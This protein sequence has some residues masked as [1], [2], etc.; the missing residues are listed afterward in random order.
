LEF[1][2]KDWEWT[3]DFSKDE[4][5]AVQRLTSLGVAFRPAPKFSGI[6]LYTHSAD[7]DMSRTMD[8][9]VRH[10]LLDHSRWRG[11]CFEYP[12]W[13]TFK[14]LA[15]HIFPKM[16]NITKL[17]LH[18]RQELRDSPFPPQLAH[19]LLSLQ[20]RPVHLH[21]RQFPLWIDDE[22]VIFSRLKHL[23]IDLTNYDFP[24]ISGISDI[25]ESN[26]CLT[27]WSW[28]TSRKERAED[29]IFNIIPLESLIL[30]SVPPCDYP[31]F[32]LHAP[33]LHS[34]AID[35]QVTGAMAVPLAEFAPHLENLHCQ[36]VDPNPFLKHLGP[37]AHLRSLTIM[38]ADSEELLD[39]PTKPQADNL[40]ND[41]FEM[42]FLRR[43]VMTLE[44]A[45]RSRCL[46][47]VT[48]Y[49][50]AIN[51]N[52]VLS[53][54]STARPE[55]RLLKLVDCAGAEAVSE[56]LEPEGGI[57]NGVRI[58]V[59]FTGRHG[60]AGDDEEDREYTPSSDEERL[61]GGD[62]QMETSDDSEYSCVTTDESLDILSDE[63]R[64]PSPVDS[65]LLIDLANADW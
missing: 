28:W 46:E 1:L 57:I 16:T 59:E 2:K 21:L 11:A 23:I 14:S 3:P 40:A 48:L 9:C 25:I 5:S 58:V 55:L 60:L 32:F 36:R 27:S 52:L 39:P 38:P 12:C 62:D 50:Q 19:A 31:L 24:S 64:T 42:T 65:L 18:H 7:T 6:S 13:R 41:D 47:E 63:G 54:V 49:Y 17:E 15:L 43:C 30:I 37:L 45:W 4:E 53:L 22:H 29:K 56:A 10:N 26:G 51:Y 61:L 44:G 34:I 8:L 35:C 20:L 33:N